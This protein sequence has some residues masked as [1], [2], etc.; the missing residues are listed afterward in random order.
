MP[1]GKN[2]AAS[3]AS[4][5]EIRKNTAQPRYYIIGAEKRHRLR[6]FCGWYGLEQFEETK[7]PLRGAMMSIRFD[8]PITN[9][10]DETPQSTPEFS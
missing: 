9:P 6:R 5:R 10:S 1:K 3:R 2:A 4:E 7:A 8:N